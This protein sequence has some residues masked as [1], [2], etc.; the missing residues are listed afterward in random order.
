[1]RKEERQ[2]AMAAKVAAAQAILEA[3]VIKL[4]SGEDWL[5]YLAFAAKLHAYSPNNA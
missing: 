1:V 2:L 4:R 5:N 3:E